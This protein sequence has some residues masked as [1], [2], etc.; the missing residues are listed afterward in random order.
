MVW[1]ISSLGIVVYVTGSL[2]RTVN[3]NVDIDVDV[4]EWY[5][6]EFTGAFLGL[7]FWVLTMFMKDLMHKLSILQTPVMVLW[8]LYSTHVFINY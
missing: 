8:P 5:A 7:I 3:D 6:L 4:P 2:I 1:F